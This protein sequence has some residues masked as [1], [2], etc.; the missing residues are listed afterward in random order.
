[1]SEL[2]KHVRDRLAWHKAPVYVF[3][4]QENEDFPKTGSGKI[5]KFVLQKRGEE[6]RKIGNKVRTKL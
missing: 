3:W 6:L 4:L 5:M 2:Q 1:M